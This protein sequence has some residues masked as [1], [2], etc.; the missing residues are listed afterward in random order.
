MIKFWRWFFPV[1]A[2]RLLENWS[3]KISRGSKTSSHHQFELQSEASEWANYKQ[4]TQLPE[5]RSSRAR[6]QAPNAPRGYGANCHWDQTRIRRRK[7]WGGSELDRRRPPGPP[8]P[9]TAD[10]FEVAASSCLILHTTSHYT[11][12]WRSP[13]V[14]RYWCWKKCCCIPVR[15]KI[16][17]FY[18]YYN[19]R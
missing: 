14:F 13:G 18:C 2:L 10:R 4:T 1:E 8:G 3:S 5:E 12:Y 9:G 6:H 15:S 17:C 19:L 16:R 7:D 11:L